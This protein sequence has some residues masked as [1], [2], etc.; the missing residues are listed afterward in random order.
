MRN[1][2]NATLTLKIGFTKFAMLRPRECILAGASGTYSVC[3]CT[4]PE[5]E[6]YYVRC[7]A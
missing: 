1:L 5:C 4:P 2:S 3:L 6:I 7:E